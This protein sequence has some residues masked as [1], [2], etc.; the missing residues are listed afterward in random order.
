[1][2]SIIITQETLAELY[3]FKNVVQKE[4]IRLYNM[5]KMEI[6]LFLQPVFFPAAFL[7]FLQCGDNNIK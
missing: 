7:L 4:K 6:S 1:M 5:E 3:A 2:M